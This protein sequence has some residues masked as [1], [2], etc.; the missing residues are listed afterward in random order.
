M[1]TVIV[2]EKIKGAKEFLNFIKTLPFV[3]IAEEREKIP[4][5]RTRK[6]IKD[7]EKGRVEHF[8]SVDDII[9][10]NT[11]RNAF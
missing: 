2:N 9:K 6:A 3:K 11:S 10:L 7:I 5:A 8:K 4:N 1:V